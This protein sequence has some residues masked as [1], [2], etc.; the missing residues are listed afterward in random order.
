M[1]PFVRK[2]MHHI[3]V[4]VYVCISC[5]RRDAGNMREGK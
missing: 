3:H 2:S 5:K 4:C 1:H